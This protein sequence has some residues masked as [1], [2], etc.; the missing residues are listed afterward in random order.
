MKNSPTKKKSIRICSDCKRPLIVR[1]NKCKFCKSEVYGKGSAV[2]SK[3]FETGYKE[4]FVIDWGE[5]Y[6]WQSN[7]KKFFKE[8]VKNGILN[9]HTVKKGKMKLLEYE[10]NLESLV[11]LFIQ[12]IESKLSGYSINYKFDDVFIKNLIESLKRNRDEIFNLDKWKFIL[13]DGEEL[14]KQF[15]SIFGFLNICFLF[16]I[17]SCRKR[18]VLEESEP[19]RG[20]SEHAFYMARLSRIEM[21]EYNI[22]R[23]VIKNKLESSGLVNFELFKRIKGKLL[24]SE[25]YRRRDTIEKAL[26][27][28]LKK[29]NFKRDEELLNLLSSVY[30]VYFTFDLE[31]VHSLVTSEDF[32]KYVEED[33]SN[34]SFRKVKTLGDLFF[35][36][37]NDRVN[38]LLK[39]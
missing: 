7:N 2:G 10:V 33:A 13:F 21:L 14:T 36:D 23:I 27:E 30:A 17:L 12:A 29:L 35:Y 11:D 24:I 26:K 22:S 8:Y 37:I 25:E 19:K 6:P 3:K 34:F 16:Y 1:K 28:G 32:F 20:Q 38:N 39:M 18:Q 5:Y 4:D 15:N 31:P 9:E